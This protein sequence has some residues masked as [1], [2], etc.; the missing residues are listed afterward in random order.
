MKKLLSVSGEI[1]PPVEP[2][3]V[4]REERERGSGAPT[5]ATPA[6][7]ALGEDAHGSPA[8][9]P[10]ETPE[11]KLPAEDAD[12]PSDD[13][14]D[15]PVLFVRPSLVGRDVGRDAAKAA[16]EVILPGSLS[17]GSR[18]GVFV[19][20]PVESARVAAANARRAVHEE[21]GEARHLAGRRRGASTPA[22]TCAP[23]RR[24]G[25][26]R[27]AGRPHRPRVRGGP[28]LAAELATVCAL[29]EREEARRAALRERVVAEAEAAAAAGD[30]G[31]SSRCSRRC[32]TRRGGGSP[33]WRCSS[34]GSAGRDEAEERNAAA[35]AAARGSARRAAP[36]GEEGAGADRPAHLQVA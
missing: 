20:D 35:A 12:A 2:T 13:A 18:T 19:D 28:Q 33:R 34:R 23:P 6:E 3:A 8:H 31:R 14:N 22:A 30:A 24:R 15:P 10:S 16:A 5:R 25:P 26:P 4:A 7:E 9:D 17:E 27:R 32:G 11:R 21:A 1:E 36:G 29:V